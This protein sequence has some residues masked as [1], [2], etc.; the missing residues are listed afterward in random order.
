MVLL[1]RYSCTNTTTFTW[2]CKRQ[3]WHYN[4]HY[5]ESVSHQKLKKQKM[6]SFP[7]IS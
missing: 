3:I 2:R 4:F 5:K 6:S 7:K 1:A